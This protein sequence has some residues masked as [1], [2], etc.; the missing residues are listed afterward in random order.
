MSPYNIQYDIR[1]LSRDMAVSLEL[2]DSHTKLCRAT[3]RI[4]QEDWPRREGGQGWRSTESAVN[5]S[6][7]PSVKRPKPRKRTG[8]AA[9]DCP[10]H[11]P[12]L[13]MTYFKFAIAV[14]ESIVS[15]LIGLPTF[16]TSILTCCTYSAPS[17]QTVFA[18]NDKRH[19]RQLA[20]KSWSRTPERR[21]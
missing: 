6:R 3:L 4:R 21:I 5:G 18:A 7:E 10:C 1:S 8:L 2:P 17:N 13:S 9:H 14:R 15:P 11:L 20:P 12:L 16:E 19:A